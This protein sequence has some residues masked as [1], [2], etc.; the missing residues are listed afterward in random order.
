ML[1]RAKRGD[2][3][4]HFRRAW[5]LNALLE[6]YFALRGLWYEG[7]KRSF[8]WLRDHDP[9]TASLFAKALKPG[10]RLAQIAKLATA[11]SAVPT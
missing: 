8:E 1:D 11:V 7:P 2:I 6:D 10:A 3:E 9:E 5:L 4:G